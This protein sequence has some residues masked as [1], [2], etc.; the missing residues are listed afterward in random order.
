M[1]VATE[2]GECCADVDTKHDFVFTEQFAFFS[3]HDSQIGVDQVVRS[4]LT[5]L[6]VDE[7]V[8]VWTGSSS[9]E[10]EKQHRQH[11]C[12]HERAGCLLSLSV[13]GPDEKVLIS[14]SF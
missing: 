5:L 3:G 9:C 1:A 7:A 8:N 10:K 4:N 2:V 12:S 11:P 6:L 14:A 13:L